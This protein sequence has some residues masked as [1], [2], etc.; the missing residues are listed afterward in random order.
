[1]AL[2]RTKLGTHL[3]VNSV[4]KQWVKCAVIGISSFTGENELA[5]SINRTEI[6]THVE[7]YRHL[8]RSTM[9]FP[10]GRQC[11]GHVDLRAIPNEKS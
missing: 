7:P 2:D 10:K 1:M 5:S 8:A 6:T 3:T 9:G 4:M 11:T